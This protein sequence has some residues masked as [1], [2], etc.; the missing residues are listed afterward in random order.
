VVTTEIEPKKPMDAGADPGDELHRL[1]AAGDCAG[2]IGALRKNPAAVDEYRPWRPLE[3]L[4][5]R[6]GLKGTPLHAA[7]AGGSVDCVR[8]L[9]NAGAEPGKRVIQSERGDEEIPDADALFL[10]GITGRKE[11]IDLLG[12]TR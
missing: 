11:I 2:L 9:L 8:M 4:I 7:V 1:A 5:N 6:H 10:A 12:Q 3:T